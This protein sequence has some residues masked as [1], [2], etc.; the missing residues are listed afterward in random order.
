MRPTFYHASSTARSQIDYWLVSA[1]G[2]NADVIATDPNNLNLSDHC[3]VI[4]TVNIHADDYEGPR[5]G[6]ISQRIPTERDQQPRGRINWAKADTQLYSDLVLDG[7]QCNR[8]PVTT[9]LELDVRVH[10]LIPFSMKLLMQQHPTQN[11]QMGAG[12]SLR[13][14]MMTSLKLSE[15][16][17]WPIRN[18]RLLVPVP[19]KR[20]QHTLLGRSHEHT[21]VVLFGN[22][23]I[24]RSRNILML[25]WMQMRQTQSCFIN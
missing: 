12:R 22:T 2:G 17:R 9:R 19:W 18:G 13:C 14:G 20:I 25:S 16:A 15:R 24:F 8:N 3:E 5:P 6:D 21:Y 7:I 23:I 11:Q 4:L 10:K 1:D